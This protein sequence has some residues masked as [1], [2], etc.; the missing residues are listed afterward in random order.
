MQISFPLSK[1]LYKLTKQMNSLC[2]R[3]PR[4]Y[5][6][7]KNKYLQEFKIKTI[8]RELGI[9]F[10][11]TE[12]MHNTK[13]HIDELCVRWSMNT[14]NWK[15]LSECKFSSKTCLQN[16]NQRMKNHLLKIKVQD[17]DD[18]NIDDNNTNACILQ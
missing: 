5:Y 6:S 13:K 2:R 7:T 3:S 1:S 11:Y 12:I 10:K 14:C 17:I 8:I 18:N 15:I 4:Q 9:I 16:K